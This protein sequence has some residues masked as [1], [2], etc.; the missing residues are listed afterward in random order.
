MIGDCL[1]Y[2]HQLS[3]ECNF[4]FPSCSRDSCS[5]IYLHCHNVEMQ[6]V[7]RGPLCK[8]L[9]TQFIKTASASETLQS[10]QGNSRSP[11]GEQ[12]LV[13]FPRENQKVFGKASLGGISV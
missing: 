4:Y 13:R 3:R 1:P 5:Y 10:K 2:M 8:V 11:E 9:Y 6:A 7:I 12:K